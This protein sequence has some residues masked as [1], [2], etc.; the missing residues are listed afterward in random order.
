MHLPWLCDPG[1]MMQSP[2]ASLKLQLGTT[3]EDIAQSFCQHAFWLSLFSD[4][5]F[6]TCLLDIMGVLP[7][8]IIMMYPAATDLVSS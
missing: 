7:P 1:L 4:S 5:L 3:L 6:F 2:R 8:L